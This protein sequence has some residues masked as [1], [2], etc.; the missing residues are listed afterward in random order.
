MS[1]ASGAVQVSLPEI[2]QNASQVAKVRWER[3]SSQKVMDVTVLKLYRG[4]WQEKL[5]YIVDVGPYGWKDAWDK[6]DPKVDMIG[7]ESVIILGPTAKLEALGTVQKDQ[8]L[9]EC[10][11]DAQPCVMIP[12]G[13]ISLSS[14]GS[15]KKPK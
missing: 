12:D 5:Q 14:L 11:R 9:F 7:K 1:P 3:F 15:K 2:L 6:A 10:R 13:K 4:S 8:V